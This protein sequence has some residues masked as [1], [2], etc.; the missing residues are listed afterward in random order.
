MSIDSF[1]PSIWEQGLLLPFVDTSIVADLTTPPT[2]V[3]GKEI[4]W[5]A[6][7]PQ[8]WKN[9]TK[10]SR[11]DWEQLSTTP[12]TMQFDGQQYFAVMVDDVNKAQ[13]GKN[14][15]GLEPIIMQNQANIL[16]EN[17]DIEVINFII[18]NTLP[19]NTLGSQAPIKITPSNAYDTIV[20]LGVLLSKNK[21]PMSDRV[22]CIDNT[23]LAMLEK[24]DR[25][26]KNYEVLTNGIVQGATINGAKV[27]VKEGFTEGK[28]LLN[29]KSSTG[30]GMQL[31][32]ISAVVLTDFFADGV[33]G[34][35]SWGKQQLRTESSAVA[36]ISY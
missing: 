27:C 26:T 30:F 8:E 20:D 3:N 17:I 12:K 2:E 5:N 35:A 4:I 9:Y 16:A 1:K 22:I 29:H 11:I 31:S 14:G 7:T 25:F 36:N 21:V 34:L 19:A 18:A 33:R 23:Y 13:L 28:I 15:Q 32:D 10:S 6:L 24:D